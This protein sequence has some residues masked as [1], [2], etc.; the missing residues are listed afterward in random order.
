MF[1]NKKEEREY[2]NGLLQKLHE[3]I[4]ENGF[5]AI[6]KE[7]VKLVLDYGDEDD[8]ASIIVNGWEEPRRHYVSPIL[9]KRQLDKI[10]AKNRDNSKFQRDILIATALAKFETQLE[11]VQY[12]YKTAIF[13]AVS[14]L[15]DL[16]EKENVRKIFSSI[17]SIVDDSTFNKIKPIIDDYNSK[18]E[19]SRDIVFHDEKPYSLKMY[20]GDV[21]ITSKSKFIEEWHKLC[22]GLENISMTYK[23]YL[24]ATN[25]WIR[26]MDAMLFTPTDIIAQIDNIYK[27][28]DIMN[29]PEEY[30]YRYR[31]KLKE[32]G[33]DESDIRYK[34]ASFRQ[35]ENISIVNDI[36][37]NVDQQLFN[38]LKQ[39]EKNL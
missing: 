20:N 30:T 8:M 32:Q 34:L 5:R 33:I 39:E 4:S 13:M 31:E 7:H 1:F 37:D 22:K 28:L 29:I 26:D 38:L 12:R 17:K 21:I 14:F 10:L 24:V 3:E 6:E 27:T 35:S 19:K 11:A 36:V 18:S 25:S 15:K 23:S 2:Y 16:M 9:T